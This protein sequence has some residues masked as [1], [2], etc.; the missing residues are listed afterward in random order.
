MRLFCFP[1]AGGG[2]NIFRNWAN[3]LAPEIEVI[4]IQLPGHGARIKEAR[5]N[6]IAPV[7]NALLP[8]ILPF[9]EKP[10]TLFGHSLGALL[11]YELAIKLNEINHPPKKLFVSGSQPPKQKTISG[12]HT[13]NNG[14]FITRLKELNGTPEAVFANQ[15]LLDIVLPVLRADFAMAETYAKEGNR[16]LASPITAFCGTQDLKKSKKDLEAWAGFTSE[17]FEIHAFP[18]DHFFIHSQEALL[19]NQL[20]TT[21]LEIQ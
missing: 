1:Y 9:S 7:T 14:E 4:A 8:I 19:L 10:L 12:I 17:Q 3:T 21:L 2:P 5:Y 11:A 16:E 20:K 15:E 13:L 18:G 6:R